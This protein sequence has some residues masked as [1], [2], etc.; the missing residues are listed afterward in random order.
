MATSMRRFFS[1]ESSSAAARLHDGVERLVLVGGRLDDRLRRREALD[2][3]RLR[4]ERRG[5]VGEAAAQRH[6]EIL[7]VGPVEAA[8]LGRQIEPAAELGHDVMHGRRGER[9]EQPPLGAHAGGDDDR[10]R[11]I[12]LRDL[13]YQG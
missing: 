4:P 2:Q 9:R 3:I 8:L 13:A 7:L 12:E 5:L 11:G 6:R 1:S 10:D